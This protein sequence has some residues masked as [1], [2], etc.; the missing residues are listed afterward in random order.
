MPRPKG[1]THGREA[2]YMHGCRCVPCRNAAKKAERNRRE[3][4]AGRLRAD[5][6]LAPHGV[7]ATYKG[8]GCRCQPCTAANTA[9]CAEF[10]RARQQ[11]AGASCR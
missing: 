9:R 7:V 8:W 6:S 3:Y 4:K 11:K 10:A 5:P 1:R 2:T